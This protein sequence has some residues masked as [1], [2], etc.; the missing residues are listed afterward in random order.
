MAQLRKMLG[1][2]HSEECEALMELIS[3]QSRV[4]LSRWAMSYA[5]EF[6]LPIFQ[7]EKGPGTALE[8]TAAL[9]ESGLAEG[10]PNPQLSKLLKELR[11]SAAEPAGSAAQAAA[12]AVSVACGVSRTPSNALGFLFYGAAAAAYSQ[13][14]LKENADIYQRLAAAELAR[15]LES[16]RR[17]AIPDEP[18][19]VKIDW[20]C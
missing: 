14:G 5:R 12:R 11:Q 13:A 1:D 3:S 2:I 6:Y 15:A 8:K 20:N 7:A 19:P 10:M 4:T 17:A 18:S 9:C 16:L